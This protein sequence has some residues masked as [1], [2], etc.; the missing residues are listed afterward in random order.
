MR[1]LIPSFVLALVLPAAVASAN[2]S[3]RAAAMRE[4]DAAARSAELAG[5][6]LLRVLD[7]ARLSGG[8]RR[9]ACVDGRLS[10]VN[11]F[12]R[13]ILDRRER[14]RAAVA[15]GD[16]AAAAHERSVIRNLRAQ[17]ARIERE[18]RSCVHPEAGDSGSTVVVTIVDPEVPDEDPSLWND[19]RRRWARP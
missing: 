16:D 18:G 9:V 14:L 8:Q 19:G 2:P 15:R 1:V 17:L 13:M 12:T 4:A 3:E 6:R 11:S 10:Q 5:Q 7:E